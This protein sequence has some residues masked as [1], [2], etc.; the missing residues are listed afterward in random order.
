[1]LNRRDVRVFA[2]RLKPWTQALNPR[3]AR[4]RTTPLESTLAFQFQVEADVKGARPVTA[5]VQGAV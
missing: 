3:N 4:Q 5:R 2:F 1:M